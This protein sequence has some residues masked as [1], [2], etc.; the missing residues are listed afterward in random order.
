MKTQEVQDVDPGAPIMVAQAIQITVRADEARQLEKDLN[1]A[2]GA[3]RDSTTTGLPSLVRLRD[4]LRSIA[5]KE[6]P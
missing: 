4:A 5:A 3:L 1:Q 6:A 2:L